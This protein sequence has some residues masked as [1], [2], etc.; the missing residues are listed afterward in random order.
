MYDMTRQQGSGFGLHYVRDRLRALYG[1]TA[2]IDF[3][4]HHEQNHT[5]VTLRMPALQCPHSVPA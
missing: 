5:L 2:T 1:D 3:N 4:Q